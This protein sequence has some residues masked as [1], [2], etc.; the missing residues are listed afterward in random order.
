MTTKE[1]YE[2]MGSN[3]EKVLGRLGSEMI[4]K[5][6]AIKFLD[7]S[8]FQ[9]LKDA[10]AGKNLDDLFRAA[11][12]LKGVCVNLGF[13]KLYEASSKITEQLRAGKLEGCDE[14]LKDVEKEYEMTISVLKE[15]AEQN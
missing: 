14:M 12:T 4:I 8:S 13:D 6:F 10:L 9:N 2:K 1:C 11:H 5:K 15:F 7:D 3:Y